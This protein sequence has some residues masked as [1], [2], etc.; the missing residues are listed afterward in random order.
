MKLFLTDLEKK[1]IQTKGSIVIERTLN[2]EPSSSI[3]YGHGHKHV[4]DK[5]DRV[6]VFGDTEKYIKDKKNVGRR[7][8]DYPNNT[9]NHWNG[10]HWWECERT[11]NPYGELKTPI[12]SGIKNKFKFQIDTVVVDR[13]ETNTKFKEG[14][15]NPV[16]K[17]KLKLV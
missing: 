4:W 5:V 13:F 17:L 9:R 12:V 11:M 1:E 15:L 7:K 6:W 16:L 10:A 14:Y 8:E 3:I 2:N